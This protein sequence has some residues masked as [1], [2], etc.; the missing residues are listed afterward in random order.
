MKKI[1]S[2]KLFYRPDNKRAIA[3]AKKITAFLEKKYPHVSL[4]N[5]S[6][7]AILA[8]G[9]DGTIL[10]AARRYE[11]FKPIIL[12]FNLGTVGFLA[13][14]RDTK[15]FLPSLKKFL[16]GD[17]TAVKHM[18][19]HAEVWRKDKNIDK[20]VYETNALNEIVMQNPL[21]MVELNVFIEGYRAQTV[22]GSGVLVSTAT[23]STGYNLSANGPIVMPSIRCFI[24]TEILDHNTLTPSIIVKYDKQVAVEIVSFRKRNLLT[25]SNGVVADTVLLSDGG[26]PF[27]LLEGDRIVIKN[28]PHFVRFA[29]LDPNYFFKSLQKKFSFK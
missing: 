1:Q 12:G 3:W 6:P 28:S 25:I 5:R 29:E 8:L 20:L 22:R 9:G 23:G 18:M 26:A 16:N 2:L 7:Q 13:S 19:L 24:I 15:D 10:E 4:S 11:R 27:P 17:Y 21:G 14:V